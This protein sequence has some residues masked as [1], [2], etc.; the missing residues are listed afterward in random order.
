MSPAPLRARPHVSS[1]SGTARFARGLFGAA[2][3]AAW[4]LSA[5]V[6]DGHPLGT[7]GTVQIELS[8]KSPLFATDLL[9]EDGKP[10][11]PRQSPYQTDVLLRIT[12]DDQPAHGA[13]VYVSVEP[14]EALTL[15]SPLLADGE[16]AHHEDGTT[17]TCSVVDGAFQCRGNGEGLARFSLTV[18]GN[19]SS[20]ANLTVTW[21]GNRTETKAINILPAGV[22]PGTTN[23]RLIGI[24]QEATVNATLKSLECAGEVLPSDLGSKWPS[25]GIRSQDVVV[26]ATPPTGQPQALENAPVYVETQTEDLMFS[27]SSDCEDRTTQL[28]LLLDATGQ[29]D[30]FF[31]CFS[32]IGGKDLGIVVTSGE[33]R[34]NPDPSVSVQPEP[35]VLRVRVLPGKSTIPLGFSTNVFELSALNVLLQPISFTVDLAFDESAPNVLVLEEGTLELSDS[36]AGATVINVDPQNIGSAHLLV[37][38]RLLASPECASAEVTVE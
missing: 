4:S 12:E 1:K 7:D 13:V 11:G 2:L 22:P 32:D 19:Y 33:D 27:M 28:R 25:G 10:A 38:P 37:T 30:H 17:P 3:L 8:V 9:D 26:R 34:V 36:G 20:E 35:R 18:S 29:S 16:G 31:A 6:E 23:F 21:S 5:C 24:D 14:A 15:G